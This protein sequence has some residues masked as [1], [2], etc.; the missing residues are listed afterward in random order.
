MPKEAW[1]D[2]D[3]HRH[4]TVSRHNRGEPRPSSNW[5]LDPSRLDLDQVGDF[6][7]FLAALSANQKK[8]K[9]FL[10]RIP[11]ERIQALK[12]KHAYLGALLLVLG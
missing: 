3:D 8:S 4:A 2:D 1:I 6:L 7:K 11:P 10:Q 12:Q 5:E 9:D